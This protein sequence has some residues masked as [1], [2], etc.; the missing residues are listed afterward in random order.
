MRL[1]V[2][3]S[4]GYNSSI[5]AV[6][7]KKTGFDVLGI[8]ARLVFQSDVDETLWNRSSDIEPADT[9]I[10]ILYQR[11]YFASWL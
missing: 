4:G 7:L 11:F 9:I 10:D 3:M 2:A 5:L 1:A 8:T 6:M